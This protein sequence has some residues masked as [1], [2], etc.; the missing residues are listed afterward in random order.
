MAELFL[1]RIWRENLLKKIA[2]I[3]LLIFLS[4]FSNPNDQLNKSSFITLEVVKPIEILL[5]SDIYHTI[6]KGIAQKISGTFFLEIK[7]SFNT[8]MKMTYPEKINL[9]N[10]EEKITLKLGDVIGGLR[11]FSDGINKG[12]EIVNPENTPKKRWDVP[13][14][15]EVKGTESKGEYLGVIEITL[16]YI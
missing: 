12:I 13:Y 6:F 7:S 8:K 14:E 10:G 3:Q 1:L 16:E 9:I 11:I 4:L 5:K 2:V 15:I